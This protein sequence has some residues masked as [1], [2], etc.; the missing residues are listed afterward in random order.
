MCVPGGAK[1]RRRGRVVTYISRTEAAYF[2]AQ[3]EIVGQIRS[4]KG[5]SEPAATA[6]EDADTRSRATAQ[7]HGKSSK[8]RKGVPLER[9]Y[10][11]AGQPP[12][13]AVVWERRR[14]VITGS[15]GSVVFKMDGA[16]IPAEWS[17]L[18]TDIVVSKY[19]RKA[20]IHGDS[21]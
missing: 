8:K 14:S 7:A 16:E 15:D 5:A 13:D 9:R 1:G 4:M 12:L 19:F 18:A 20:G 2:M 17:Q 6:T 3:S 11:T 21:T 10:T